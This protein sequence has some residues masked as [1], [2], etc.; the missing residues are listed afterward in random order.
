MVFCFDYFDAV[1]VAKANLESVRHFCHVQ[2]YLSSHE[3]FQAIKQVDF[4][5]SKYFHLQF[6]PALLLFICICSSWKILIIIDI[7][8]MMWLDARHSLIESL[9]AWCELY[10]Y[11]WQSYWASKK[12]DTVAVQSIVKV[13]IGVRS[14]E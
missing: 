3:D 2:I 8:S 6:F 1:A 4:Q 11:C 9:H 13:I 10:Y 12:S 7:W 14:R 5:F